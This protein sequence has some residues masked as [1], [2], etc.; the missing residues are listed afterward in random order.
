MEFESDVF[1][2]FTTLQ[3]SEEVKKF[4]VEIR[5]NTREFHKTNYLHVDAL[6]FL[7]DQE[8]MK[9]NAR[10]MPNSYLYTREGLEMDNGHLLLFILR[11]S[12]TLSVNITP[13]MTY[14]LGAKCVIILL[15]SLLH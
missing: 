1:P 2:G 7:V 13:Q 8:T 9:K 5:C 10:Q 6:T 15:K 3:V 14:F 11:E 4:T 12:D